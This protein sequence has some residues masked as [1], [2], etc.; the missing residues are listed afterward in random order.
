MP[1]NPSS[2][3]PGAVLHAVVS[4]V[5][6]LGERFTAVNA[7]GLVILILGVVLF[8]WTKYRRLKEDPPAAEGAKSPAA[9]ARSVYT[10]VDHPVGATAAASL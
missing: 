9:A 4:A 10:L 8:N 3:A 1:G 5:L 7:L 6:F 2:Q